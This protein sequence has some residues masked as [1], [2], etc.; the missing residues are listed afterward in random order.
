MI[1]HNNA[2]AKQRETGTKMISLDFRHRKEIHVA[3]PERAIKE[4]GI[5]GVMGSYLGSQVGTAL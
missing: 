2:I 3:F 1:N 4:R 5:L